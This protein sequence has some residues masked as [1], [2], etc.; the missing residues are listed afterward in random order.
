[1]N[2]KN[3]IEKT[4]YL[5]EKNSKISPSKKYMDYEEL[6]LSYDIPFKS[7][8]KKFCKLTNLKKIKSS[9]DLTSLP[10]S[11]YNLVN[12]EVLYLYR[13]K[14]T[15]LPESIYQLANLKIL[16][17]SNNDLKTLPENFGQLKKLEN[18]DMEENRNFTE[19][20][21]TFCNLKNL[22]ILKLSYSGRPYFP[23]SFENLTSLEELTVDQYQLWG[24]PAKLAKKLRKQGCKIYAYMDDYDEAG[25]SI[26]ELRELNSSSIA[27]FCRGNLRKHLKQIFQS[28]YGVP[29]SD[30][31]ALLNMPKESIMPKI[32]GW[33]E[34]FDL[35][36]RRS[37]LFFRVNTPSQYNRFFS[38]IYGAR[39][40]NSKN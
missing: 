16:Q 24:F 23:K 31:A 11:I 38:R 22:R 30:L 35:K 36:V 34:E 26:W 3:E 40:K 13:N 28:A 18:F 14:L 39:V 27:L 15:K 19:F 4:L 17:L 32:K 1:M 7:F 9:G 21:K 2:P 6:H 25:D 37:R 10:E 29:I 12:L 20:P 33:Q 5:N 8:P